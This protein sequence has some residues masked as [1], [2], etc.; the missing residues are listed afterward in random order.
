MLFNCGTSGYAPKQHGIL[1]DDEM[2]AI[3]VYIRHLPPAGSLGK[4]KVYSGEEGEND[5][6]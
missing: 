2:W 1:S 6:N 4:P 3:V 5:Q